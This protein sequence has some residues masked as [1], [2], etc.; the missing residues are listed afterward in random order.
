MGLSGGRAAT[1]VRVRVGAVELFNTSWGENV[2]PRDNSKLAELSA[3]GEEEGDALILRLASGEPRGEGWSP[4]LHE[5]AEEG[6]G[7]WH[8]SLRAVTLMRTLMSSPRVMW[9]QDGAI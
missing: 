6:H 5:A 8:R 2:N 3:T 4:D 7:R 9:A 1:S